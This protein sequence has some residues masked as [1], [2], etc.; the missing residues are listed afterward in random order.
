MLAADVL[1]LSENIGRWLIA[2]T[3]KTPNGVAWPDDVMNPE[4]VGFDLASGVAGKVVY[5]VALYSATQKEVYLDQAKQGAD[6]LVETLRDDAQFHGN[7]RRASLY[8]GVSGVGIALALVQEYSEAQ[9]YSNAAAR[10]IGLLSEWRISDGDRSHWSNE[11]NDLIYGDAGTVL[12]FSWYPSRTGDELAQQMANRGATFLLDQGQ[13]AEAGSFWY[14][15][16]SQPFN[17]PNFSHG[18]AG[19]AY[20]LATVGMQTND[21]Q[22]LQGAQAGFDY[23]KL[24]AEFDDG[25]LRIPYGWPNEAWE[26]VYEFGWAHGLAGTMSLFVRLQQAGVDV[27]GASE[28]EQLSRHTLQHIG[29][30]DIPVSPYSEPAT[31][32]DRRFGR[33][34]VLSA[35]SNYGDESEKLQRSQW[36]F[37]EDEAI[38]ADGTAHWKVDPPDFM[39]GGQAAYTG[40]FHGAAGIGLSLLRWHRN[41]VNATPYIVLPDDP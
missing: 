29:L 10:V 22:L 6:F 38:R 25:L 9:E 26:G 23:I 15:R 8:T 12:F 40:L 28:F 30:P 13:P 4:T 7:E 35:I 37:L 1:P 27:S 2:N 36:E 20:V 24:I 32:L 14:F 11:F 33:A 17:L 41:L 3:V 21:A 34:G 19:I 5:W 31:P 18:T 39:G 16:R